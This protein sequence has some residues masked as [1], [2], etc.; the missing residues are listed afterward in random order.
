MRRITSLLLLL[1]LFLLGGSVIP[2]K[3][4]FFP[5]EENSIKENKNTTTL[6]SITSDLSST[7]AANIIKQIQHVQSIPEKKSWTQKL[8]E[9][10][11]PINDLFGIEI[12]YDAINIRFLDVNNF[13]P[14]LSYI[15]RL[16]PV[17]V[18]HTEFITTFNKDRP[19]T[20]TFLYLDPGV[21]Y[22]FQHRTPSETF[23]DVKKEIITTYNPKVKPS[24]PEGPLTVLSKTDTTCEI[25]WKKSNSDNKYLEKYYIVFDAG[26]RTEYSALPEIHYT[27][28]NLIP[29]SDNTISVYAENNIGKSEPISVNC[30][31]NSES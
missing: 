28:T 17:N 30:H 3:K 11:K 1:L 25:M 10:K 18:Y 26:V 19:L 14:N 16:A 21:K 24:R 7:T 6:S 12:G 8:G 9:I 20:R 13:F 29:G 5:K 27:V 31:T 4:I 2:I 23:R 22:E 15:V